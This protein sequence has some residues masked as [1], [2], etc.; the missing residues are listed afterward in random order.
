MLELFDSLESVFLWQIFSVMFEIFPVSSRRPRELP[1]WTLKSE[2]YDT[3]FLMSSI[4]QQQRLSPRVWIAPC[5][6]E[7]SITE[8]KLRQIA[9]HSLFP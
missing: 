6:E 2:F 5:K 4:P 9:V 8:G 7:F 3:S 1:T